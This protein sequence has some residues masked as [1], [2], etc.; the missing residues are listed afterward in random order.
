MNFV[1][2]M[3]S[4]FCLV[5]GKTQEEGLKRVEELKMELTL[6]QQAKRDERKRKI[7]LEQGHAVLTEELTKEKVT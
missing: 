3:L 6:L 1:S 2:P 7:Q 5:L 4:I